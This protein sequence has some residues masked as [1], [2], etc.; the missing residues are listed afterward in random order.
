MENLLKLIVP[1]W[2]IVISIP[3]PLRLYGIM[4][5]KY[6][7]FCSCSD[8]EPPVTAPVYEIPPAKYSAE[9][10]LK[11]L[12]D[13]A[14]SS[15]KI[16]TTLPIQVTTSGTYVVDVT[17]L[18]HPDDVKKDLFGV[19]YHSGSHPQ[20]CKVY[21]EDDYISVEKCAPGA[22]GENVVYLRRLHS[23]HPSNN[24]FKR[25]IAFVSGW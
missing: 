5:S 9:R 12:C 11:I 17:K 18:S 15:S 24:Q 2:H 16:C 22:Q 3:V 8:I 10:I 21:V 4:K 1:N 7:S 13:P 23:V 20:A 14:I 6:C 25:M 19:W